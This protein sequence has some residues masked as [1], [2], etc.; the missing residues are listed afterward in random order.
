MDIE[1]IK[2]KKTKVK[3]TKNQERNI[4]NSLIKKAQFIT[5]AG[6]EH[7][8]DNALFGALLSLKQQLNDNENIISSWIVHGNQ[9]FNK[10]NQHNNV[11]CKFTSHPA[12]EVRDFIKSIGLNW[13][14]LTR[15]WEGNV[16]D[17]DALKSKIKDTEHQLELVE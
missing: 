7:L 3:E 17:L 14:K 6:L 13:N 4:D 2:T 10:E 1:N 5:K 9:A 12:R 16:E 11:I 15:R 8:P